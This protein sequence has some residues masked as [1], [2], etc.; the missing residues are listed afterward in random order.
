MY[1]ILIFD[2]LKTASRESYS[3]SYAG[4]STKVYH[5]VYGHLTGKGNGNVYADCRDGRYL[6]IRIER[7]EEDQLNDIER[8]RISQLDPKRRYNITSG[9]ATYRPYEGEVV[10]SNRCRIT[11][12]RKD[13][14]FNSG[15]KASV[16]VDGKEVAKLKPGEKNKL[17]TIEGFHRIEIKGFG[18]K[19][20][21][22]SID[23]REGDVLAI[24]A[25][26]TGWRCKVE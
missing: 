6:M 21:T 5:R 23:L 20:F 4:Q 1:T 14:T 11:I 2:D 22:E 15:I 19:T 8:E 12:F 17:P 3:N 18:L 24:E 9:G 7:C 16:L 26:L 13:A 25:T 10:R